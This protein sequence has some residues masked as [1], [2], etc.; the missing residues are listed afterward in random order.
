MNGDNLYFNGIDGATGKY[1]IESMTAQDLSGL[2]VGG[3][4]Q[5]PQHLQE[6]KR[7][8]ERFKKAHLAPMPGVD[9][10]NL[11][12]TGW[13]VIFACD[14]D[15]AVKEALVELLKLRQQQATRLKEHRYQEYVREKEESKQDFLARQGVGF[16][17]VDPDKV[18]YYLLIVGSPEAIPYSFQYQLDVQYAVGRLYFE[19]LVDYA[20]YARSV[21]AAESGQVS[22]PRRAAFFGVQNPGD[23]AT[24]LSSTLLVQSLAE[25]VANDKPDWQIKVRLGEETTKERLKLWLGGE[26]TPALLFTA[27][28]GMGFPSGDPLQ[29]P[30]QGALLCQDWP[31]PSWR[32]AIPPEFYF[33]SQDVSDHANLLGLLT[34]HFACFG[35]GTPRMDDFPHLSL[36]GRSPI[37]PNAF[38]AG[39]PLRLL[40]HPRGGALAVVGHVER[41]W[42]YSFLWEKAGTQLAV[43]EATFK[44]LMEGHPIGSALEFFNQRYAEIS[45]DLNVQLENIKIGIKPDDRELSAMWTANNDARSFVILGDPAVRLPVGDD[46]AAQARPIIG[47]MEICRSAATAPQNQV[48]PARQPAPPPPKDQ[49]K[50]GGDSFL[51]PPRLPEGLSMRDPDLY[52]SWREHI[53]AGFKHNEE[54]F[55]DVLQAFMRPYYITVWMYRIL[56]GAGILSFLVAAGMSAWTQD[57]RFALIFGG[58]GI[59]AFLSYFISRP[60]QA[61]EENLQ[62]ITWLGIVYN[63]YWTRLACMTEQSTIQKDLQEAMRDAAGEIEKIINKHG[64][65]SGKRPR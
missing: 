3:E 60:L 23:Q 46:S 57:S 34:F 31:G 36:Q 48:A 28:H 5:N 32:E 6:L 42:G 24:A 20:Q 27:S 17:P 11:A 29:L 1:L 56:F 19:K 39:L 14:A 64:E 16:G 47:P 7:W 58:L 9:P 15:P 44:R 41:A 13:G 52:K 8:H 63:T 38:V 25:I 55:Q 18:P 35:A 61:L 54:M 53:I 50:F 65:V 22:L 2:I 37:A 33:A 62:F 10:L 21:V 59:A 49:Q 43:F 12:E 51:P 4:P 30:N 26:N 45:S 40:S